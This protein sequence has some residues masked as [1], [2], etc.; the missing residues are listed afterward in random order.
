MRLSEQVDSSGGHSVALAAAGHDVVALARP[1]SRH[2]RHSAPTPVDVADE[3]A[4][5]NALTGCEVAYY[6]VHS[7]G[8]GDFREDRDR[9]LAEQCGKAAAAAGVGRIVYLGGLGRDPESEHLVS[10][11]EV[12]TALACGGVAIVELRRGRRPRRGS[13]PSSCCGTSPSACR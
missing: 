8:A 2:P 11:Q 6:L 1:P 7:L 4:L 12:G 5:H 10:R 3:A 9:E 13:V